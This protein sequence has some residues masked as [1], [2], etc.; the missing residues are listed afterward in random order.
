M[1]LAELA[2]RRRAAAV[3]WATEFAASKCFEI[4]LL[5]ALFNRDTVYFQWLYSEESAVPEVIFC[6]CEFFTEQR[7]PSWIS[8]QSFLTLH[9]MEILR[10]WK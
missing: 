2:D 5:V 6:F 1:I 3:C 7:E 10:D 8:K 9:E 4:N